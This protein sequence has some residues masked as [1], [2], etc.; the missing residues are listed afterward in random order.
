MIKVKTQPVTISVAGSEKTEDVLGYQDGKNRRVV[1][2]AGPQTTNL[3]LVAYRTS[4]QV[5]EMDTKLLTASAP[6]LTVNIPLKQGD[7]FRLGFRDKGAGAA[8]YNAVIGY[9]ESD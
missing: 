6:F 1:F 9:E 3:W 2:V 4:E 5:V 8:T 7:T